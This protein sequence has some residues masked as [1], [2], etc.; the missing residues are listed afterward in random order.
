MIENAVAT[1]RE[2]VDF[3]RSYEFVPSKDMTVYAVADGEPRKVSGD[4]N[5]FA[6]Q[7]GTKL[8]LKVYLG[9]KQ[10]QI[11]EIKKKIVTEL[12]CSK[13]GLSKGVRVTMEPETSARGITLL[14]MKCGGTKVTEGNEVIYYITIEN[15]TENLQEDFDMAVEKTG[16][17]ATDE[18][19]FDKLLENVNKTGIFADTNLNVTSIE[20][21]E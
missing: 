20:K 19:Y 9:P 14:I 16:G 12:G 17:Q 15:L 3:S 4:G 1:L 6:G 13:F 8:F 18:D 7:F 21:L 11:D 5:I 2:M 10:F